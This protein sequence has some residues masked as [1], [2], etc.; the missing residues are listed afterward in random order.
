MSLRMRVWQDG[1]CAHLNLVRSCSA[2]ET[3][4][5]APSDLK[6]LHWRAKSSHV[7][8]QSSHRQPVFHDFASVGLCSKFSGHSQKTAP[9]HGCGIGVDRHKFPHGAIQRPRDI[10]TEEVEPRQRCL[11]RSRRESSFQTPR[12]AVPEPPRCQPLSK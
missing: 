9:T 3:D 4:R 11:R 8:S 6:E 12:Q 2:A 5:P 10:S 1:L 7:P